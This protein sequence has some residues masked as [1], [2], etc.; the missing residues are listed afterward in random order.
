MDT[1]RKADYFSTEVPNKV[2]EGA[3][4]LGALRDAG[5]NLTAFTA[6][7]SGR[8]AQ[9]DFIAAT[10]TRISLVHCSR[11]EDTTDKRSLTPRNSRQ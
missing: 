10:A 3:R 4:L 6:F 8:R 2:G 9:I 1:I 7:P 11:S 5:I